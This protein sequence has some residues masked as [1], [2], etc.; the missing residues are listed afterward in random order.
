MTKLHFYISDYISHRAALHNLYKTFG[1]HEH[2]AEPGRVVANDADVQVRGDRC[3]DFASHLL[4]NPF[5]D[6]R[7]V[8]SAV[9]TTRP[10]LQDHL[11]LDAFEASAKADLS[12]LSIDHAAAA[13]AHRAAADH[14]KTIGDD[15]NYYEHASH[16]EDHMDAAQ[17]AS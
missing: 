12:G 3:Q 2:S 6:T 10:T 4:A 17:D 16:A 7:V 11:S 15:E 5:R 9:E 1:L 14:S 13:K 8:V